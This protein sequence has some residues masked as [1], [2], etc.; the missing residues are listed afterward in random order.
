MAL[1]EYYY[2]PETVLNALQVL[3]HLIL[4]IN[5]RGANFPH[6]TNEKSEA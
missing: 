4:T 2:V 3:T 6:F 5:L 1:I